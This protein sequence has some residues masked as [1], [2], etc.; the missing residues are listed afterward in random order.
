VGFLERWKPRAVRRLER[1]L[2]DRLSKIPNRLNEFQ[3]DPWGFNPEVLKKALLPTA[4]F[5]RYWFRART[6]GIENVPKGRV[7]LVANHAGQIPIDAAMLAT[8]MIL[9]AEPPRAVRGMGEYWLPSLPWINV[10]LHRVGGVVG[11]PKNCVDLLENEEAVEVFPEG[12]RGVSKL[13]KDRYKLKRFGL[14]FMRL[15]LQMNTPI[16]PVGIVGSEEQAPALANI[17]PLAKLLG[18]P[19][20][21]V[22]PTWPLL[23]PLG[24]IPLPSRYHIHFGKPM[25][26]EGD[27]DDEDHH[28]QAKVDRVKAQIARL[29]DAGRRR[30]KGVFG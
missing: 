4:L 16:L 13:F 8:A 27:P 3:Y 5:Y 9:E 29:I 25:V 30:R 14:G 28:I 17:K 10:F 6:T 15:A 7:L 22:T 21:P 20:F 2:E 11:T 26:F 1:E 19:A 12:V 24:L 23:G 18:M